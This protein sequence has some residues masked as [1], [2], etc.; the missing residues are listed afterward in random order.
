MSSSSQVRAATGAGDPWGCLDMPRGIE[1]ARGRRC[2][3]AGWWWPSC[4][5]SG[6]DLMTSRRAMGRLWGMAGEAGGC[7]DRGGPVVGRQ[8]VGGF[9]SGLPPPADN[10][11]PRQPATWGASG[12]GLGRVP[13]GCVEGW[14]VAY[15]PTML[16]A[17]WGGLRARACVLV[18]V[19]VCVE[20]DNGMCFIRT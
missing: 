19:W 4:H 7:R 1:G 2:R 8:A 6:V 15:H 10:P 18:P 5:W 16:P 11:R 20:V 13:W 3:G 14:I 12:R 9:G 17:P